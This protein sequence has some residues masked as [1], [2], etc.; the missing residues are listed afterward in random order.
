MKK[1]IKICGDYLAVNKSQIY[2]WMWIIR[3]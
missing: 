2:N 1:A 3:I